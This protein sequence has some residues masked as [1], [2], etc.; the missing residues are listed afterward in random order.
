M[1]TTLKALTSFGVGAILAL[2]TVVTGLNSA[3][4]ATNPP[5]ASDNL[6]VYDAQ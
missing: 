6:V 5:S 4:S 2:V 1:N 3:T